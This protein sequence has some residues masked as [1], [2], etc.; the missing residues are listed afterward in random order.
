MADPSGVKMV[1][2]GVGSELGAVVSEDTG[3]GD[4]EPA[5]LADH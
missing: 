3:D 1:A 5:E 4:P 2:E